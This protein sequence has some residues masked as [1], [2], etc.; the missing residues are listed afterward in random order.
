MVERIKEQKCLDQA[1]TANFNSNHDDVVGSSPTPD[2]RQKP[3]TH[4]ANLKWIKRKFEDLS[5]VVQIHNIKCLVIEYETDPVI[6]FKG[7]LWWEAHTA[8]L[9]KRKL[10]KSFSYGSTPYSLTNPHQLLI[11]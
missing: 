4:A 11:R 5:E 1:L 6:L 3:Q 2:I 10:C 8:I 9:H 7:A